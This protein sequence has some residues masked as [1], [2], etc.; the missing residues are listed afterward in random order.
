MLATRQYLGNVR[1]Q[2]NVGKVILTLE[3]IM[4][5]EVGY[6]KSPIEIDSRN[7]YWKKGWIDCIK[8][9]FD[10]RQITIINK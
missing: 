3:Q 10:Q 7:Y 5:V 6:S 9:Y 8:D 4:A 2:R 1:L